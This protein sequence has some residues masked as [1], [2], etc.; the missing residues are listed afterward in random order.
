MLCP[1]CGKGKIVLKGKSSGDRLRE[2]REFRFLS[3]RDVER[4]TGISNSLL[5]QY[6]SGHI[7]NPPFDNIMALCALYGVDPREITA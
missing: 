1:L 3:L 6:E 5:C 2:V 4:K 7:V